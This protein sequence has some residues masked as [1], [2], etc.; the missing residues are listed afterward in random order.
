[1]TEI[2]SLTG[3]LL[4]F[5]ML[6]GV[7]PATLRKIASHPNFEI[8]TID[9]VAA[10]LPPVKKAFGISGA[11][12]TALIHAEEQAEAAG[13]IDARILSPLDPEYPSLLSSTKDDP[14]IIYVRGT[15]APDPE[16]SVAIIGTRHPTQHGEVIATRITKFFVENG[17][18]I[19]SGL[20]LGCDSVAHQAALEARGHTVAVLA[21]GLHTISP[22][23]HKRLAEKILEQGGALVSEYPFGRDAIPQQFVKRDKTQAGL[24]Q[25]VVM[26]QSDKNGGSM[27]ASRAALEY[28]RWLAVPY[29]TEQDR[30]PGNPKIEANI[31]LASGT[32]QDKLGLMRCREP[33]I[34][35]IIILRAKEDYP[36]LINQQWK[37]KQ[38]QANGASLCRPIQSGFML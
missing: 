8:E 27:H 36:A 10:R 15:L 14:F 38:Q 34:E 18:S 31:L 5:S 16:S 7:G 35:R 9:D 20:A 11:W 19:V 12:S 21:H 29:P 22:A 23:Q 26:I 33:D 25:G 37:Y 4:A 30:N 6:G 28:G 17:W 1:M 3:R 2:S 13:Q 24:A 32:I